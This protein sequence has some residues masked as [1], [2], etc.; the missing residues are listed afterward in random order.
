MSCY[1]RGARK[2]QETS[3]SAD[4]GRTMVDATDH[5]GLVIA[6]SSFSVSCVAEINWNFL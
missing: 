5:R 3:S 6:A 2:E 4:Y 1:A